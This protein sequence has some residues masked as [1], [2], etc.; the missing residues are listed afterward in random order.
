MCFVEKMHV[1]VFLTNSSGRMTNN[2]GPPRTPGQWS[3][4]REY[5]FTHAGC[6]HM[7]D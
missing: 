7:C 4:I 6:E 5:K 3:S 1:K 2:S